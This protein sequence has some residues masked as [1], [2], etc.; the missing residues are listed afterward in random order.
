MGN[1]ETT[2]SVPELWS[3]GLAAPVKPCPAA[4]GSFLPRGT[5]GEGLAEL[6]ELPWD[7]DGPVVTCLD[8]ALIVHLS[9]DCPTTSGL[10]WLVP[11][12]RMCSCSYAGH[13]RRPLDFLWCLGAGEATC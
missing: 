3:P 9:L 13:L 10:R 6:W 4:P 2:G 5:R 7:R 11:A 8:G 1:R 12:C